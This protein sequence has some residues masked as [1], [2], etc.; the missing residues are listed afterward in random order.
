MKTRME[1]KGE[2]KEANPITKGGR[3]EVQM[4]A[5]EGGGR[6]SEKK[7]ERW[8]VER[9]ETKG[10]KKGSGWNRRKETDRK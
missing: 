4:N 7:K 2:K 9:R 1:R 6:K 5:N 3:E 8:E 10:G